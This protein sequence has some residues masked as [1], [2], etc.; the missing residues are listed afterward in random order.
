[1]NFSFKNQKWLWLFFF[2][3]FSFLSLVF[4]F[5]K[6]FF[7]VW[8]FFEISLFFFILL[9]QKKNLN[10][11][12]SYFIIFYDKILIYFLFQVLGSIIILCGLVLNKLVFLLSLG[13]LIKFGLYPFF[14]WF[15]KVSVSL[16]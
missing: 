3:V 10:L 4:V 8:V 6:S 9:I 12:K 14:W 11:F 2:F 5:L 1:M 13:L 16:E 7:I 15:L